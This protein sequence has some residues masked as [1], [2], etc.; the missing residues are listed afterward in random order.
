MSVKEQVLKKLLENNNYISG[1]SLAD[2]C[3][4]TRNSIWK[5]V[6]SLKSD[7]YEISSVPNKGY[8]LLSSNNT[9]SLSEINTYLG[10]YSNYVNIQLY[11]SISSTNSMLKGMADNGVQD[12]TLII[13]NEQTN[14]KGRYG[15]SFYSPA[16]T[17]V[18]F[19]LLLRPDNFYLTD[20]T[21]LTT[22][23]AVA[24]CNSIIELTNFNPKIKWVNDIFIDDKKICGILSEA[25]TDIES[26]MIEYVI[27]GIGLNVST[28]LF[29][30]SLA[31]KAG[32][33]NCNIS[34][35]KLIGTIIVNILYLYNSLPSTSFMS[36]YKDYSLMINKDILYKKNNVTLSGKVIDID[37]NGHLIIVDSNNNTQVLNSGEVTLLSY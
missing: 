8:Q 25:T 13:A 6:N 1:Q 9:L 14:G 37:N 11:D 22:L 4:V 12:K 20:S 31:N 2:E 29:P 16:K 23:S 34:R 33:L 32:S 24:I 18:Y 7:G 30:S 28:E 5:A 35:N 26:G 15:R 3:S 27:I 21:L 19:S 36:K 17:G 10:Q